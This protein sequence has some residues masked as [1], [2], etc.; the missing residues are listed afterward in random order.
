MC[1]GDVA[2]GGEQRGDEG[3]GESGPVRLTQ[4]WAINLVTRSVSPKARMAGGVVSAPRKGKESRSWVAVYG[5]SKLIPSLEY[6]FPLLQ[7]CTTPCLS[8]RTGFSLLPPC[9][10]FPGL[11]EQRTKTD[12]KQKTLS[13]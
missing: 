1:L 9:I 7:L 2:G 11:L 4:P 12:L 3:E 6:A 10:G 13:L 8:Q 5:H